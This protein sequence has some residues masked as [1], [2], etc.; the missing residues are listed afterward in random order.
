MEQGTEENETRVSHVYTAVLHEMNAGKVISAEAELVY[1]IE[2]L[3]QEVNS[4][5][6]FEQY[7]R[8][9]RVTRDSRVLQ[10]LRDLDLPEVC[11]IVEQAFKAAFPNGIPEDDDDY[12]LCL[13]W[14]AEQELQLANLFAE[15]ET[16]N[17]VISN[18]LGQFIKQH[19]V[20]VLAPKEQDNGASK[21]PP[22]DVDPRSILAQL[23]QRLDPDN[24]SE[25]QG[26][27]WLA[28]RFD[29]GISNGGFG[30]HFM[31]SDSARL[32]QPLFVGALRQLGAE[33]HAAI[34]EQAVA[35]MPEGLSM[36]EAF[37]LLWEQ[38]DGSG[39]DDLEAALAGCS[40]RLVD[41]LE[42]Y[43]VQHLDDFTDFIK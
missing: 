32:A 4:G 15:F 33:E 10:Y 29:C 38:C 5:A 22:K 24:L 25:N 28:W 13:E 3:S 7:F 1:Q 17:G 27:V 26:N 40:I 2:M 41:L 9:S 12:E 20:T 35:R 6:S 31:D 34:L 16:C 23:G 14:S 21:A 36:T 8:W 42:V 43:V 18:R 30:R 11:K 37:D 39:L 19:K